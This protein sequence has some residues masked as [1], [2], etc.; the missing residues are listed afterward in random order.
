MTTGQ[1]K[2]TRSGGRSKSRGP[3]AAATDAALPNCSGTA[4]TEAP[5]LQGRGKNT[6]LS[7]KSLLP[8]RRDRTDTSDRHLKTTTETATITSQSEPSTASCE[9]VSTLIQATIY[10]GLSRVCFISSP[11]TT[12]FLIPPLSPTRRR[13]LSWLR[14]AART[15]I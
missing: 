4:P 15:Q 10:K 6:T 2:I 9:A 12:L 11:L 8:E 13:R 7:P 3:C 5:C 14:D 1:Q